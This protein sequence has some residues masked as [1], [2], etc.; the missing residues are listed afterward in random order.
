MPTAAQMNAFLYTFAASVIVFFVIYVLLFYV[1][2]AFFRRTE[3]DTALLILAISQTP[4][5][6]IF[7]FASLKISLFQ[8][9]SGGIIDWID[10]GLT[11][12][13]IATL[14]YLVTVFFTEAAIS[15]LKDYARKTEAVWDDVLIPLL[16]NCIPVITYIIGISLFFSTLGVDLSGIG[17]AIGSITVVLGLAIKDILSD[18]FSGLVLLVDT[19]FKFGDVISMPDGSIAIIKQIGIRVTKLY[20]INEHCE[21]YVPNTSLGGQNIVNLSRPTTHY[22]YTIKV[23]VRV[24]ADAIVATKI[25]QEIIIG[26]P[27]T[28]GDID[29]K[30]QYLDNFAALREAE[31]DKISKK[32]AGRLRLLVEKDVN[33]Q[34]QKLEQAFEY[35]ALEIKQLEKGGLN[36]EELRSIQKTYLEILNIAGLVVIT[37]RKGKRV[38]SRLEEQQQAGKPTLIIL[39]RKWYETWLQDPDLVFEDKNILPDEWEQKIEL[40]KIKLN[41]IFQKISNPGVDETRLDDYSLKFVEWLHDSFKE[42]NTAWKEPQ[43]QLTDIQGSGMQFSVRF[44]VDNIQLE[45]WRR[46]NRVQNEV[47]REMVRRLRQAY[48]YTLG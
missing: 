9:G 10:R 4:S 6:T 5:I 8:L 16:Q 13:L 15:Y 45:H 7:I 14:T 24:D 35:F 44:Y 21:V 23:S 30:L 29:E 27:D 32:E 26:H 39:I 43:V 31:D 19:P 47:R 38:R 25:L 34:L 42:S 1:L 12:L 3:K 2:R 37:E 18:F 22:A 48:I 40:L 36:S 28:L 11:A 17:L 33:E 41:K 20:L 46:G